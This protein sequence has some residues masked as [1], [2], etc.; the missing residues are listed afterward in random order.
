MTPSET[1][2]FR[3]GAALALFA[4]LALL[5]A[6]SG[7]LFLRHA[8]HSARAQ[9]FQ[10]LEAI[11]RLKA[12]AVAAWR[13][14][15]LAHAAELS[16]SPFFRRAAAQLLAPAPPAQAA[17]DMAERLEAA[18]RL[19][20]DAAVFLATP[21]GRLLASARALPLLDAATQAELRRA[22]REGRPFL[23]DL[24]RPG[25]GGP[26]VL[27]AVAPVA[28]RGALAL[29][30]L[31]IDAV[32]S[33][34]PLIARWPVPS[35]SAE[36]LL[37]ERQ[38]ADALFLNPLRFRPEAALSLRVPLSKTSLPAVKA[39]LGQ[40]GPFEGLDYR[41][42][43]VLADLRPVP[44]SPWFLVSKVDR[45]EILAGLRQETAAV[46]F[47]VLGLVLLSGS[48][49]GFLYKG[50]GKRAYQR[51]LQA[52]R[53]RREA[54]EELGATL[55]GIG[56]AV[57][58]TDGEGRVRLMNPVAEA[59]TGWSEAEAQGRPLREVFRIVNETT[60]AEAEDPV[61]RVLR[62]GK[63][64]GL[65]NHTL[66]L[67]RD[68]REI[69]V[70]DSGAPIFDEAGRVIG[71]VLVFR[72]QTKERLAEARFRWLS[73]LLEASSNEIYTFDEKS[74]RF[75]Y[76]NRGALENLGFSM[77]EFAT[78]TP[79]DIKP[80]LSRHAFEKLVAPLR[81]GQAQTVRLE[82]V[83]RRKDG[84]TYPILLTLQ[85]RSS[86]SGPLFV[87]IGTDLTDLRTMQEARE[88]SER[89][90][91]LFMRHLPAVAVIR[92]REG[93]YVY[94]NEAWEE[95]MGL[96]R[97]DYVGKTPL[98]CFPRE[99]AERL[100]EDDRRLLAEGEGQSR[101]LLLHH[102]SG[103]RW[104]HVN[105]FALNDGAGRGT[106]VAALYVD[107]TASK[108]AAQEKEKLEEHLRQAQKLESIGRLAGGVAHDFNNMLNIIMI[109]CELALRKVSQ[110]D[111]MR[112]DLEEVQKAARRSADLTRQLL[113]FARKQQILP[114]VIDLNAILSDM[115]K[116][117][118]RLMGEEVD[119]TFVPGEGLWSLK[120][121]PVQI[122]QIL[123]NLAVNARDAMDGPGSVVLETAN[124]TLDE[125][126]H[127][128]HT[129]APA[130]DY[131]LMA[132]SDT[133]RGMDEATRNQIFE[134]F[135]TT[136]GQIGTGLGLSTVFGI[137]KQNGGIIHVY[138]EPGKGTTFK[139]YLPRYAGEDRPAPAAH[140]SLGPHGSETVLVAEDE[141]AIL[142]LAERILASHGYTVLAA[143]TPQEALRR[144]EGHEGPIH[145][146]LTDVVMPAM[147]GKALFERLHGARP[148][149]RVLY[150]SGYTANV[151]AH[152][153]I[154]DDGAAFLQKPFT[155]SGLLSAVRRTLA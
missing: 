94:M 1:V 104:W 118:R 75:T 132:F 103:A 3:R 19:D 66:L 122:D 119:F 37:V 28:W 125:A 148:E 24:F 60:R 131:V 32:R 71:V 8:R 20:G 84:S 144:A 117:L 150:M 34:Y 155:I 64:V 16:E 27:D 109:Y 18:R 50:L 82:T 68:G 22:V 5:M 26:V 61:A 38:G 146:L 33:L 91:A 139:I 7:A 152:R 87:A 89:R 81:E 79:L 40:G 93:R 55:R 86:E 2:R 114:R 43:P 57:L 147:N 105:R 95:A 77:E 98:D 31:R 14:E 12:E 23:G 92:D 123:A 41:G 17:N 4:L 78:R 49:V 58:A 69:P 134:P 47:A 9:A 121:D 108:R 127:E 13:G 90:F 85:R 151:I 124:V 133:G 149:L 100:M 21:E 140:E 56:D 138:S 44:G 115:A 63:V 39:V 143:S 48:G 116:M 45:A 128:E 52:E 111:L 54:L 51:L 67:A 88:E 141:E 35:E 102:P 62:E 107:I 153:G 106:H 42:V 10:R 29:L 30:V 53:E 74:L 36:T 59:L 126:Y 76:A 83:H 73:G 129:Y 6:L 80:L 137:V 46:L 130:G 142:R 96:R 154:V 97:E 135:F 25:G 113:A 70:A 101:E 65:A 120:M 15:R 145:L 112:Q 11:G 110:G 99:E 72:D 136:K